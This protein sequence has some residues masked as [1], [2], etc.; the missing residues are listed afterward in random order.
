MH[1]HLIFTCADAA[2][3]PELE[4]PPPDGLEA[5]PPA[6]RVLLV[7]EAADETGWPIC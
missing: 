4:A 3:S 7:V 6:Y 5:L 1:I 2:P